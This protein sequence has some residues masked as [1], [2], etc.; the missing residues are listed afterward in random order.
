[1]RVAQRPPRPANVIAVQSNPRHDAL[2]GTF[3]PAGARPLS[4]TFAVTSFL[5]NATAGTRAPSS[6]ASIWTCAHAGAA[7]P[8]SAVTV[9]RARTSQ[10]GRASERA[11]DQADGAACDPAGHPAS[12]DA[13]SAAIADLHRC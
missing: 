10:E 3:V 13:V 7:K 12:I 5:P 2:I 8:S 4:A 11:P 1:M 6:G 9:T